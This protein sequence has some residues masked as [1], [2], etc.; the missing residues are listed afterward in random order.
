MRVAGII[1]ESADGKRRAI[2]KPVLSKDRKV[3]LHVGS[4]FIAN[5]PA[6]DVEMDLYD[7]TASK[8]G[9]L[10]QVH[11]VET[12]GFPEIRLM[13][14]AI[15]PEL[16]EPTEDDMLLFVQRFLGAFQ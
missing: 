16:G 6:V 11:R 15:E 9:R 7:I 14:K 8:H 2:V 10:I 5:V 12:L 4:V 1:I 3:H 13:M